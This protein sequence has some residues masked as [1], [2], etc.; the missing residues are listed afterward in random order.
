ML[1]R[2]RI[3]TDE[4]IAHFASYLA[5]LRAGSTEGPP[6]QL[7]TDPV[8]SRVAE[9][10]ALVQRRDF[11][12][13]YEFGIYLVNCLASFNQPMLSRNYGLWSWLALYYFDQ[14]CPKRGDGTRKPGEDAR[15]L[16]SSQLNWQRSYRQ[17]VREAWFAVRL[18]GGVVK[19][20]LAGDLATRGDIIEQC[21]SRQT[22]I[23]NPVIMAAVC[24][25][26]INPKTGRPRKGTA[27]KEGGSPRRLSFVL[28][29]LDL[30]FDL[31]ASTSQRIMSLLPAE[32]EEWMVSAEAA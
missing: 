23:S 10:S 11:A 12:D 31:W 25:L 30:T 13:R 6:F 2:I 21:S 27:G 8:A 28:Q 18:N 7:L 24:D 20:L 4:G 5:V 32:F 17:L 14:T 22:I 1:D 15:H 29:Q 9:V 19:P 26:Y 16:L 3:L